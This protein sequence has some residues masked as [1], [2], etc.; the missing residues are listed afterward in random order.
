MAEIA[1]DATESFFSITHVSGE[2]LLVHVIHVVGDD[3][4]SIPVRAVWLR[5]LAMEIGA[6][7]TQF[8]PVEEG[9][10]HATQLVN[11][12]SQVCDCWSGN[13]TTQVHE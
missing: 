1:Q 10:L 3:P 2:L 9:A 6:N 8:P 4:G 13:E 12:T 7:E 5:K 11:E